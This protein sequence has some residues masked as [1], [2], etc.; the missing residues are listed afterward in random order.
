MK[1]READIAASKRRS[2]IFSIG[3]PYV[4]MGLLGVWG[5]SRPH[6]PLWLNRVIML[7]AIACIAAYLVVGIWWIARLVGAERRSKRDH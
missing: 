3:T 2:W 5:F 4:I 7:L 6:L 1:I